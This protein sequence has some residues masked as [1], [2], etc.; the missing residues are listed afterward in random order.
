MQFGRMNSYVLPSKHFEF[1]YNALH[2]QKKKKLDHVRTKFRDLK[3]NCGT[4][5]GTDTI[6]QAPFCKLFCLQ[7]IATPSVAI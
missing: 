4:D 6:C 2:T 7:L 3:V 5:G 1:F